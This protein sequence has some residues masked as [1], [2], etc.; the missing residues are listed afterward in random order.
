MHPRRDFRQAPLVGALMLLVLMAPA[1]AAHAWPDHDPKA[2]PPDAPATRDAWEH[3]MLPAGNP[4]HGDAVVTSDRYDVRRYDLDLRISPEDTTVAGVVTMI[5]TSK[6]AGLASCVLDFANRG[7]DVDGV[8]DGS[9][10]RPFV[11]QGDSL[12]VSLRAPLAAGD[13]DSLRIAYSGRPGSPAADRGLFWREHFHWIPSEE[14]TV[15][16][17]RAIANMSEPSYARYW[18]PCK[19]RPD[20]KADTVRV[21]VTVP[22]TLEVA[23]NGRRMGVTPAEPGWRTTTWLSTYP[24]AT[25]LVSVAV[26]NYAYWE[27]ACTTAL[28]TDLP[29]VSYVFQ[30]HL[31]NSHVEFAPL[32]DMID[33]CESWFGA[34]P[35]AR[36]KYGHAEFVWGGAMEHQTCTS[37][38]AAYL[39]GSG[40]SN[41]EGVIVHELGHQWFGDSLT[42][43]T[44][45]DIWLNEGFATYAEALWASRQDPA[46]GYQDYMSGI[47]DFYDWVG[48]SQV[49]DP[50]PVFPGWVIYRKGAWILHMVRG[51]LGDDAFFAML[52]DWATGGGRPY[53]TVT[54]EEFI[55]HASSY[56][57]EDLHGFF[58]PYLKTTALPQV[59]LATT[60]ADGPRGAQTRLHVELQQVQ[61][62]L[63]DNV[64]PIRVA[65][66]AG[67]TTLRVRL[68]AASAATV[69]DVAAAVQTVTLDP[70]HWVLWQSTRSG[71]PLLAVHPNPSAADVTITYRTAQAQ[72]VTLNVYDVRGRLVRSLNRG[73]MAPGEHQDT[74]DGYDDTSRRV[75]SGVYWITVEIDGR[76]QVGRVTIVR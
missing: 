53:H 27:D 14:Q 65:T 32:C 52:E 60:I 62:P 17:G 40:E 63:F 8:S 31:A 7:L 48:D 37:L 42:P 76:R 19:D 4:E 58:D 69:V 50:V 18:W 45:A 6:V 21:A 1:T 74:W 22:D 33:A 16:G 55:D 72:D 51:R 70:E 39:N 10:A 29:L 30:Q 23:S 2:P 64:Y 13:V 11:H 44:W 36:E 57:G 12:S 38:G 26:S 25:Y 61:M 47:R 35:F 46:S 73:I 20:D 54:T 15:D 66:A 34:Y 43:D 71:L 41:A 67:D 3:K 24:I 49:Y 68:A 56:A 75:A 59:R 5:F 9:G 28:T